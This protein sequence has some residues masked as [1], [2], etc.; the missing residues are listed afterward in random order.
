M[1]YQED[2]GKCGQCGE[3]DCDCNGDKSGS[4]IDFFGN[5]IS[6]SYSCNDSLIC[7][8]IGKVEITCWQ[9]ETEAEI[10]FADFMKTW[11]LAQKSVPPK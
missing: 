1:S 5:E 9:I 10:G 8:Y 11:N 3:S 2:F 7:F 4:G 6:W